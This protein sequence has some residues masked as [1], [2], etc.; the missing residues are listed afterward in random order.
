[1]SYFKK[2]YLPLLASAGVVKYDSKTVATEKLVNMLPSLC[3]NRKEASSVLAHVRRAWDVE[4][5]YLD[6]PEIN[7]ME[8]SMAEGRHVDPVPGKIVMDR[9][10]KVIIAGG[11]SFE[12]CSICNGRRWSEFPTCV[13][14]SESEYFECREEDEVSEEDMSDVESRTSI[15]CYSEEGEAPMQADIVFDDGEIRITES[16]LLEQI[17]KME[18]LP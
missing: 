8:A 11:I 5:A 6:I 10:Q 14:C 17:K 16:D 3:P 2:R 4:R 13:F 9:G 1:M 15:T 12:R 7:L 18:K